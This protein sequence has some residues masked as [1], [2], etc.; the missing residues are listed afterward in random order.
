MLFRIARNGSELLCHQRSTCASS[1][2]ALLTATSNMEYY[3]DHCL[4]TFLGS[5]LVSPPKSELH[6]LR[7]LDKDKHTSICLRGHPHSAQEDNSRAAACPSVLCCANNQIRQVTM[8][9]KPD[10]KRRYSK[11]RMDAADSDQSS[12]VPRCSHLSVNENLLRHY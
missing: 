8:S 2:T 6:T 4:F 11:T 1:C 9:P 10:E 3:D 7:H 12:V 5:R